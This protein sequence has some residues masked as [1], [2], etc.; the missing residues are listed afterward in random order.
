MRRL[1]LAALFASAVACTTLSSHDT[2]AP[3]PAASTQ[4]QLVILVSIDGMPADT[5]G[6]GAMPT[7]DAIATEGVRAQWMNPS[8]PTLTFPNHYTLVTGLR[9]DRHGIVHNNMTDETL[10]RFESKE[11]RQRDR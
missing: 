9:P 11:R 10:G 4:D 3:P 2:A 7:L 5:I 1:A 6:T 8:Q